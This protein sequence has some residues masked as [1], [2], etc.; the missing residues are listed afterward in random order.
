[1][2]ERVAKLY[3]LRPYN[4]DYLY[5]YNDNIYPNIANEFAVAAYRFGHSLVRPFVH[6]TRD[7]M[8]LMANISLA[9]VILDSTHAFKKGGIDALVR[10]MAVDRASSF[11]T[12]ITDTLNHHLFE[13]KAGDA[14]THRFSLATLNI[15]RGRDHG[16]QPYNKYRELCGLN[17]A[18]SFDDLHNMPKDQRK[19][20]ESLYEYVHDIDLFVGGMSE[21]PVSDGL[22]G[23]TFACKCP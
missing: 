2:G 1:M 20:L 19:K 3:H 5:K 11:D 13:K 15:N 18:E 7:D 10:G 14:P 16:V 23:P 21:N 17:L 8:S 4:Q 6:K 12:D 22:V 9:H